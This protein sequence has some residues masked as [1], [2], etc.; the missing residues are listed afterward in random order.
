MENK[1]IKPFIWL[2]SDG[3][4]EHKG[5]GECLDSL[6]Q[7]WSMG[8]WIWGQMEFCEATDFSRAALMRRHR[9]YNLDVCLGL[10]EQSREKRSEYET[11][12]REQNR[13]RRWMNEFWELSS[14]K[15]TSLSREGFGCVVGEQNRKQELCSFMGT[16]IFRLFSL[17]QEALSIS[18]LV[19]RYWSTI[20]ISSSPVVS[21]LPVRIDID[22]R[23]SVG[24]LAD[25]HCKKPSVKSDARPFLL[26]CK[27]W[28]TSSWSYNIC[29]FHT[30]KHKKYD[31]LVDG[32]RVK[33][34]Q[35]VLWSRR[36]GRN[37]FG[38]KSQHKGEELR[39]LTVKEA[40]AVMSSL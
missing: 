14:V 11:E 17:F 32:L 30:L 36:D 5:R 13:R 9:V 29:V 27:W 8:T 26:A 3:P 31:W 19:L 16:N 33:K 18:T 4:D 2:F 24:A 37:Y 12:R 21:N 35:I 20:Q 39:D 22:A 7:M 15:I 38:N 23:L 10:G 1:H 34:P 40:N 6:E 25:L 28:R